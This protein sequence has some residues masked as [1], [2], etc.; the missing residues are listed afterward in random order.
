[1]VTSTTATPPASTTTGPIAEVCRAKPSTEASLSVTVQVA[2]AGMSR[3][4][5]VSPAAT[6]RIEPEVPAGSSHT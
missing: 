5:L 6:S 1:M 2:P 3:D 4:T